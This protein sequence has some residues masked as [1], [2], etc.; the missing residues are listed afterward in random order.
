MGNQSQLI[1][2]GSTPFYFQ[3]RHGR[4]NWRDIGRLDI[5]KLIEQGDLKQLELLLSN[6]TFAKLEEEDFERFGDATLLKLFKLSQLAI[7]YLMN[8][9]SHLTNQTQVLDNAYKASQEKVIVLAMS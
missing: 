6:L 4:I 2:Q 8:T 7:E 3:E 9:Q 1:Y 5:P